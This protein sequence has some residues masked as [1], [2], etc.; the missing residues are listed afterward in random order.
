M[1]T[2]DYLRMAWVAE[3][4]GHPGTRDVLLTLAIASSSPED[5]WV[6]QAWSCLLGARP[7]HF[8][9]GFP[10]LSIA[11]ENPNIVK[12]LDKLR[13]SFPPLRIERLLF[14]AAVSSGKYVK[15]KIPLTLVIY[16]LVGSRCLLQQKPGNREKLR[17]ERLL[18]IQMRI[19]LKSVAL[20]KVPDL[21]SSR[22]DA[23]PNLSTTAEISAN[24]P[25][26]LLLTLAIILLFRLTNNEQNEV[27]AA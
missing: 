2:E 22:S 9:A 20:E 25:L 24:I 27:L 18:P 12:S 13:L 10:S 17:R 11:L 23:L 3:R 26:A 8:L 21:R 19:A 6:S 1:S 5:A 16:D 14:R 7:N 4:S 15:E